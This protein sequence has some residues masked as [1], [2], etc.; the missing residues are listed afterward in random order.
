VRF[1]QAYA[2][3]NERDYDALVKAVESGK[4]ACE[5]GL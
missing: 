2:E 5:S 4:V 1:S 3:Q